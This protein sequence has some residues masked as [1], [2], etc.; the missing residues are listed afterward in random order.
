[1][2]LVGDS[3][4]TQIH[5]ALVKMLNEDNKTSCSD[6]IHSGA[7]THL[8]FTYTSAGARGS[9][10]GLYEYFEMNPA[11]IVILNIG[12]HLQDAGDM[13]DILN[14]AEPL[15]QEMESNQNTTLVFVTIPGGHLGCLSATKP[16][17]FSE[18][19]P[20][21]EVAIPPYYGTW[22]SMPEKMRCG[23]DYFKKMKHR[24]VIELEKI[25]SYR[26]DAHVLGTDCVHYCAPGPLDM[27]PIILLNKLFMKEI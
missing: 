19:I 13:W 7:T 15:L 27:F 5:S 16:L 18:W 22:T 23:R 26:P 4:T 6:Q 11:D 20:P 24:P 8:T 14:H 2:L 9:R 12:L 25:L 1:M 10:Q 21:P 3:I 17:E